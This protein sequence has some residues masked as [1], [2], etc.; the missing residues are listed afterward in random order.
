MT[1]SDTKRVYGILRV[2]LSTALRQYVGKNFH[3]LLT[4][5]GQSGQLGRCM[6]GI[7]K[8]VDAYELALEEIESFMRERE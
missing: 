7:E 2:G 8:A 1:E 5:S 6:A 3:T 4:E